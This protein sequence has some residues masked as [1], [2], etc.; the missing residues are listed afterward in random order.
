MAVY[1]RLTKEDIE[2]HLE[3]YPLGKLIDFKEIV[4]GI[5]NSNFILVTQKGKFILTIFEARIQKDEL[6]FFINF[7]LHL[8]KKG[9]CCPKPILNNLGE[10]ISDLKGKKSAIASF[11]SGTTLKTR[12]DGYY[13]TITTKHCYEVGKILAKMHLAAADFEM[14]RENDLGV[15]GWRNLLLKFENLLEEYEEN[16]ATEISENID[17]LERNWIENLPSAAVHVDLFPDNVFFD[18]NSNLSGV[19][20]F[21]FAAND[22]LIYDFAVV[23]NAWCF[24]EHNNFIEEKFSEMMRGY[25]ELREFLDEEKIFLKTALLGAAMRFL[26]TRLH[27][28]FFTPKDSLVKIKDPQE[29]LSKVRFFKSKLS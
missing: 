1:T 12:E 6:P 27:D 9:I 28:M 22:V 3:N 24:D 16:I 20:D 17:F 26:L 7:K 29:Y 10:A 23:V 25:E 14:L 18:E 19:I 15:K 4:E 2:K 5:D 21:Y 13:D 11:L 8:A